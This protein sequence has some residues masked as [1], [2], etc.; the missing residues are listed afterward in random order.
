[1]SRELLGLGLAWLK[2]VGLDSENAV[3]KKKFI[4]IVAIFLIG[5]LYMTISELLLHFTI[6]NMVDVLEG[7]TVILQVSEVVAVV[8]QLHTGCPT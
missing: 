3:I 2:I 8:L 4:V 6:D 7:V 5:M 1:M